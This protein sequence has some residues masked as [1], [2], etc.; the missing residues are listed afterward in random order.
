MNNNKNY[1]LLLLYIFII[2]CIVIHFF[3]KDNFNNIS[4]NILQNT[5][6][7]Q[8]NYGYLYKIKTN[9]Q[10]KINYK[11]VDTRCILTKKNKPI[12][13][14]NVNNILNNS[15]KKNNDKTLVT[16]IIPV[17]NTSDTIIDSI[18]SVLNQT[19]KNIEVIVINDASTDNSLQKI[20][21]INDHR[22]KVLNNIQ[23]YGTYISINIGLK[24]S[25]GNYILIH[26]SDDYLTIDCISMFVEK[27]KKS[28]INM[29]YSNWARGFFL[30]TQP[31]GNFMFKRSVLDS[32]GFL[33]HLGY[34]FGLLPE[35]IW[36]ISLDQTI[37]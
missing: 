19:Y 23:N 7:N 27:L 4:Q 11:Y 25:L 30:Q 29:A 18:A 15:I 13:Y 35:R 28:N 21:L 2:I 8:T 36:K 24:L 31:E 1:F 5:S 6:Y 22:I 37:L 33:Y 10:N 26:G 16:I 34:N 12:T 3:K 20:K 32:F 17:Y 14:I 9:I